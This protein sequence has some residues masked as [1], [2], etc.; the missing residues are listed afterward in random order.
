VVSQ[1]RT[2]VELCAGSA[3][4]SL[5]FLSSRAKPPIGYQ[6]GKRGYAGATLQALGLAPGQGGRE[7]WRVVLVEAGPWAEAWALWRTAEGRRDTCERM[8][9]W[10]G[11]DPRRLWER[12]RAAPVPEARAE[13]VAVWAVLQWWNVACKPAGVAGATWAN[14]SFNASVTEPSEWRDFRGDVGIRPASLLPDLGA[15]IAALPDLSRVEVL[16]ADARAV[17]PIPDA[18]VYI[19]PPYLDT[20]GYGATLPRPDLLA[21]AARWQAAGCVVAVSEAEPLPLPGWHAHRLPRPHGIVRS[22]SRQQAEY[23]TI[24]REPRGQ[25]ALLGGT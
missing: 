13:R 17:E 10:A 9:A 19:D 23:L 25:L 18:L 21:L 15:R 20:T 1:G 5:R 16:H 24:S 2:F 4:V 11:E 7:G 14:V 8:R 22:W 3:A 12:L 6:G